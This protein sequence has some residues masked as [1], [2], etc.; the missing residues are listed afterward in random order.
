MTSTMSTTMT[1]TMSTAVTP[2]MST[3]RTPLVTPNPQA[4]QTGG[5]NNVGTAVGVVVGIL[6]VLALIVIVIVVIYFVKRWYDRNRIAHHKFRDE[7][8]PD[9]DDKHPLDE[10]PVLSLQSF[11]NPTYEVVD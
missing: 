1:P 8:D 3:A 7:I 4:L 6:C 11:N 2:T 10:P 5:N 9:G